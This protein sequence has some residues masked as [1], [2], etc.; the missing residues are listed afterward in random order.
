MVGKKSPIPFSGFSVSRKFVKFTV[1]FTGSMAALS[2]R[3]RSLTR[4][5]FLLFVGA[6]VRYLFFSSTT[7]SSVPHHKKP[8][9]ILG[10]NVLERVTRLDKTL[11]V[12]KHRF[13]QVRM[14]RDE[15]DDLFGDVVRNGV[16]D[17]WERF[18]KP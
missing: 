11:N 4:L 12:Q 9:E 10:Y 15:R 7:P 5:F 18:Q 6:C 16:R 1:L 8:N 17:Y 3:R 14:G 13:L 2:L